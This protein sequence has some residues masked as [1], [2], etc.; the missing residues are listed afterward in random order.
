VGDE[1]NFIGGKG[2]KR[3]KEFKGCMVLRVLF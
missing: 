1:R 3:L 2:G